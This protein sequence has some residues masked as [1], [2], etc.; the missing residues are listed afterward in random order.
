MSSD[1]ALRTRGQAAGGQAG[2][3]AGL[4]ISDLGKLLRGGADILDRN[5]PRLQAI[6]SQAGM[7]G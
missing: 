7:A 3:E 6:A 5:A 1:A 2:E 4:A